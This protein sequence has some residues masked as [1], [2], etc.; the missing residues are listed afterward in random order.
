VKVDG[1]VVPISV[2]QKTIADCF[3]YRNKFGLNVALEALHDGWRKRKFTLDQ[4][5][6]FAKVNRVANVMRP[7]IESLVA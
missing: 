6:R 2:P 1:V 4:L 3:K 7:Y 5:T